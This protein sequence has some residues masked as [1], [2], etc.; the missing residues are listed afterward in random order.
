MSSCSDLFWKRSGR[1]FRT[2]TD[3]SRVLVDVALPPDTIGVLYALGSIGGGV[4]LY[5]DDRHQVHESP[6]PTLSVLRTGADER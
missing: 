2:A 3:G 5:L 1:Q 4:S 6:W